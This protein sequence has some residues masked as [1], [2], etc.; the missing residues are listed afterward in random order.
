MVSEAIDI[1]LQS[2]D[3][4]YAVH[5]YFSDALCNPC[6]LILYN[7][8]L[9]CLRL[10]LKLQCHEI[11][12][13]YYYSSFNL[14]RS[15]ANHLQTFANP[16]RFS[17]GFLALSWTALSQADCCPGQRWVKLTRCPELRWVKMTA[18][19]GSA[20]S[21]WL[22]SWFGRTQFFSLIATK[23]KKKNRCECTD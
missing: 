23:L 5:I 12:E 20:E 1:K 10:S 14:I 8:D 3:V 4:P 2:R 6:T 16:Q 13:L 18:V 17:F 22:L 21:S 19:L 15:F 7:S 11:F 9:W